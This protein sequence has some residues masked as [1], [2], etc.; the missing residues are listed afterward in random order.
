ML[1]NIYIDIYI[2][3]QTLVML[4]VVSMYTNLFDYFYLFDILICIYLLGYGSLKCTTIYFSFL[5]L[6]IYIIIIII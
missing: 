1:I 5:K 2:Y 4:F 3:Y 6:F